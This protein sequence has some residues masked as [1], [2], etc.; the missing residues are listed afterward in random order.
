MTIFI[1]GILIFLG[2]HSISIINDP[3][4]NNM[5]SKI[6]KWPWKLI[7]G[8]AAT[9]GLVL[10]IYGYGSYRYDAAII[11]SPPDWLKHLSTLVLVPVFPLLLAAYLP[12][13]IKSKTRHPMLLALKLWAFAHLLA[14]GSVADVLLFGSLL[15]W[16]VWDRISLKHRQERPI[17]GA[18]PSGVNDIIAVIG[19][20]GLYFGFIFW[21]HD[22]LIGVP[23]Y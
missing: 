1:I 8:L 16:A 14:N 6:G 11:Y 21:F 20:L 9:T 7:Y 5:V 17:P 13:R 19:G 23:V 12:G 3:W 22:L 15:A 18:P 4:R 2:V 10:L